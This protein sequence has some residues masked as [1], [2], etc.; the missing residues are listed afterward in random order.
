MRPIIIA[1]V[2]ALV[3]QARDQTARPRI[4]VAGISHESNSFNPAKTGL[5]EF[6]RIRFTPSPEALK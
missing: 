3:L 1:L 2:L 6:R 5:S 4:A